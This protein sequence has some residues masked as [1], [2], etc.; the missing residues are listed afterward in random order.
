VGV[1]PPR[2]RLAQREVWIPIGLFAK[3]ERF[4][5]RDNHPGTIGVGRLKPGVTLVQMQADLDATYAQ[6]RTEYPRENAGLSASG[7]FLLNV[8]L[9]GIRPALYIIA[10]AVG[11]VLLIAC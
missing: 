8:V 9:G 11:L 7:D 5:A 6:L 1:L 3:T 10:G 2:I 4:S